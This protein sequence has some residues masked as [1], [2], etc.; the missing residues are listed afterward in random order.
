MILQKLTFGKNQEETRELYY[1]AGS[2][3]NCYFNETGGL[4]FHKGEKLDLKTYFNVFSDL[5]WRKYT[6]V[7]KINIQIEAEGELEITVFH[8]SLKDKDVQKKIRLKTLFNHSGKACAKIGD[9]LLENEGMTGIE[10]TVLSEEARIYG[11]AFCTDERLPVRNVNL[12]IGICT[13]KREEYVERNIRILKNEIICNKEALAYGHLK[14]CIADNAGTLPIERLESKEV[15]I[16]KNPNLGGV[17]GFTR[18]MLELMQNPDVTHV[19][20]MDDDAMISSDS[21]ERTYVFLSLLKSEYQKHILGGALLRLGNP[22][23]QYESG[24][25]WCNGEIQALKHDFSLN[26]LEKILEN[27]REEETEYT[28]WWYSCIPVEFILQNGLPLPLFIHRDDIEYGLRASGNFI[29]LNGVCVWHEAFENKLPGFLE[30]Y[31]VRNLAIV[32]AIHNPSFTARDFKKMLLIQVSSNVGK[33]R[34]KYVDLN[35]KGA[36]DFLK[37][38]RWF[39]CLDAARLHRNLAKYNYQTEE[40]ENFV[41]YKGIEKGD[42]K[43]TEE[44]ENIPGTLEK[45]WKIVT[46]NGHFFPGKRNCI[47]IVRPNPNIYELYRF[48]EVLFIDTSGNALKVQRSQKELLGA[49]VKLLK[50]FRLIDKHYNRVCEEY[51]KNYRYLIS[52]GFWKKYLALNVEQEEHNGN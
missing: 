28:G 18:D 16:V 19:L 7:S 49:Y 47:K 48:K 35:L 11:G 37:G 34:Y 2:K 14:V 50:V 31:D 9:I 13:F 42:L 39:C 41:G 52:D 6:G 5:K 27:D 46:L 38:F 30:Y 40:V 17:G 20:L 44:A 26:I 32:N 1:I 43:V 51:R 4:T 22:E 25:R 29:F 10:I 45:I 23:K 21:L 3:E 8:L 33:Y 24:A 12:G 15:K 36:V